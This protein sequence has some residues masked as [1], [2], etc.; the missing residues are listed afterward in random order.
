MRI[1]L[2][3]LTLKSSLSGSYQSQPYMGANA[4][5]V[6]MKDKE[7]VVPVWW[8]FLQQYV[9]GYTVDELFANPTM[10]SMSNSASDEPTSSSLDVESSP[11]ASA[12]TI[13]PP[14]VRHPGTGG[15]KTLKRKVVVPKD[16]PCMEV[17]RNLKPRMAHRR[18]RPDAVV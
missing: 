17:D 5:V 8:E 10:P 11:T 3:F 2:I 7:A 13:Q 16:M 14:V 6:D 9:T 18:C 15:R 4:K 1:R 12:P